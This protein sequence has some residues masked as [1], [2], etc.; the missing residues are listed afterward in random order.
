[1]GASYFL[2]FISLTKILVKNLI[3]NNVKNTFYVQRIGGF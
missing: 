1:M 2:P 3:E